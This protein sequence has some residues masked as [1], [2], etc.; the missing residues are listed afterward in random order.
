MVEEETDLST[1]RQCDLLSISR[2]LFYYDSVGLTEM[3]LKLLEKMDE[4]FTG[5]ILGNSGDTILN[6]EFCV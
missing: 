4:L 1:T 6:L 2:G 3:D 5:L